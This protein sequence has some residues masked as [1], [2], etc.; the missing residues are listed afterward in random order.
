M[1]VFCTQEFSSSF[2]F[3]HHSFN[4]H[5]F[6]S[7]AERAREDM[8]MSSMSTGFRIFILSHHLLSL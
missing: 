4:V 2:F 8:N 7:F 3:I 5:F 6:E 1:H